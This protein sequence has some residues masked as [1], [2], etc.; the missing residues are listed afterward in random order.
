MIDKASD[1]F[2]VVDLDGTLIRTDLLH[3]SVLVLIKRNPFYL[4]ALPFWLFQGKAHLKQEIAERVELP[5]DL[6]PYNSDLLDYLQEKRRTGVKLMLATAS[7]KRYAEAVA[8][9]LGIFDLVL[10]SDANR[11]LSGRTKLNAIRE[12]LGKGSFSYVGN[13]SIDLSIWAESDEAILV[14]SS[15]SIIEKVRLHTSVAKI[16]K[17]GTNR[18]QAFLRAIRPHQWLKNL[19]LFVPL[20]LSHQLSDLQ[21]VLQAF[22][23]FIAFSLCASSVYLFN[24]LFDLPSDRQ[25]PTKRSRPFAAGELPLWQGCFCLAILF[26]LSIFIAFQ[27]SELFVLAL[28]TYYVLSLAYSIWL[29]QAVLVDGLTLAALYTLRL[30]AGAAVVS[31]SPSFWLLAFSM[32]I[33]LS[34]AFIKRYSELQLLH[35]RGKAEL[36]GRSYRYIDAETLAQLGTASGYLAVLVLAFYINSN[37][38]L[39][40]Y[41]RPEFL[42][43][44]CPMMLYWISRMW[45]LARRNEMHEDPVVFTIKDRRTY[46]I[47]LIACITLLISI[48]WPLV[49]NKFSWFLD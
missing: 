3:E 8:A 28:I 37:A 9:Y 42:W 15:R 44:L 6:L 48:F 11:N 32:F 16:F 36:I 14:D 38:V 17:S 33:F 25:H 20:V 45:L 41:A 49:S 18:I 4:I 5:I 24:D 12:M 31:V 29:K 34:L 47:A 26:L 21:L 22:L 7:N 13:S 19:L 40:L 46:W 10:A 1:D 39:Q 43:L 27:L 23:G 2:L 35:A 30:I